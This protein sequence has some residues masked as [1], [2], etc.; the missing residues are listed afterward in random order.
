MVILLYSCCD[1]WVPDLRAWTQAPTCSSGTRNPRVPGECSERSCGR[2]QVYAVCASLTA[3][4]TRPGTQGNKHQQS[5]DLRPPQSCSLVVILG[6]LHEIDE[7]VLERGLRALKRQ[8]RPLAIGSDRHI[9][10]GRI[11]PGDVQAGAER[12]DHVDAAHASKL[13]GKRRQALPVLCAHG[14][15]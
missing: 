9:E 4:E 14:I 6:P 12:R 10:R 3:F 2:R 11:A 7:D 5:S 13:F 8:T 1:S 15:G